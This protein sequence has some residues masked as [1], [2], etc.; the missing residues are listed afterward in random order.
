[1]ELRIYNPNM[2]FL[3]IIDNYTS[4]L[5]TRKYYETGTFELQMPFS[6]SNYALIEEGNLIWKDGSK[7]A[8]VIE[9]IT[10]VQDSTSNMIKA[11]GRFLS[12]YLDRRLIK[13]T[14]SVSNGKVE[15]VMQTLLNSA[16][17]IPKVE[18]GELQ[19][20]TEKVTFQ[21]TYKNLLT[22]EQKLSKYADIAYRLRPDFVT[23]KIYFET[24]RGLDRTIEQNDRERIVFSEGFNNLQSATYTYNTQLE[25]N[26]CYVG[27]EGEGSARTIVI[28][29]DDSLAGLARKEEFLSATDISSDDM[30]T[31]DYQAA[32]LQRGVDKLNEDAISES[33]ESACYASSNFEYKTDYDL[34]DI[35]T[36][37]KES[38]GLQINLRIT[39]IQETYE[40]ESMKVEL[41]FGTTIPETID[42][43]DS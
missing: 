33:F 39:Q 22:Y 25:K 26:V 41:T 13:G 30:T 28:A 34:G 11:Q 3:G 23:K 19:G 37:K 24:Y 29:G 35:V 9:Y 21:A 14:Y 40:N 5:W 2:E 43:T 7:E 8:G 42:W 17:A 10:Q 31:T 20:Y 18:C 32:L 38:W 4:L 27:G 16:T 6:L 12:S 15:E 36:I 1:M